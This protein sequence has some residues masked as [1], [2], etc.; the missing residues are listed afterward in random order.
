MIGLALTLFI[1]FVTAFEFEFVSF[2]QLRVTAALATCFILVKLFDWMRLFS[3][4][5]FYI[6][7]IGKTLQDITQFLIILVVALL[8]FG[9]PMVMLDLNRE[10]G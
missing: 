9:L 6:L 5:S 10:S 2:A 4:T 8:C 3:G 1:L 7:L